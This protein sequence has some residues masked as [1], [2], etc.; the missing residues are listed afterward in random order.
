MA[1]AVLLLRDRVSVVPVRKGGKMK[2]LGIALI[3]LVGCQ[4]SPSV[5]TDRP[6]VEGS[7]SAAPASVMGKTPAAKQF[8]AWLAVFNKG[9]RAALVEYHAK[10]FPY[11][12]ASHDIQGIEREAGLSGGTGGFDVKIIETP[13]PTQFIVTLK[14][15]HSDQIARAT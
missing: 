15:K 2:A 8:D 5:M 13:S 11:A 12:V 4:Q 6:R 3:A 9:D 10:Q 14:E 1:R 7:G